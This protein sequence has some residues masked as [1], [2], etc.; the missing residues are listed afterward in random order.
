[1]VGPPIAGSLYDT[2]G[3]YDLP[4]YIAGVLLMI[5]SA[6]SFMIPLV[7]KRYNKETASGPPEVPRDENQDVISDDQESVV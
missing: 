1:M 2:T 6:L 3:S 5:S 4:F 7:D